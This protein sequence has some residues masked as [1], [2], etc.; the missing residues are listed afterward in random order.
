VPDG[1]DVPGDAA[2]L[3]AANA[4]SR[5]LLAG[6]DAGVAELRALV[7]DLQAQVAERAGQNPGELVQAAVLGQAGQAGPGGSRARPWAD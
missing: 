1:P 6:R 2:G 4:R 7:A 3:R 5:E